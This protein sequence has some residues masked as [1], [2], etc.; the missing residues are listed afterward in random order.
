MSKVKLNPSRGTIARTVVLF[1]ALANQVFVLLGGDAL[2]F[3]DTQIYEAVSCVL[4]VG[5]A[6]LSWW[7]NQSFTQAAIL[8][9]CHLKMRRRDIASRKERGRHD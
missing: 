9:D 1:A 7:K 6:L 2:P 8:A 4:T 3:D 5:A